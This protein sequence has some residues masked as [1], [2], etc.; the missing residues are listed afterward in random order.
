MNS[1]VLLG[2]WP[3]ATA[4]RETCR[5]GWNIH[6]CPPRRAAPPTSA[7]VFEHRLQIEGRAADDLEHVGGGGLLLQR[8]LPRSSLSSRVF[9]IAMTAWSAKFCDQ[10]D[11]L[12]GERADLL[13]ID[14]DDADQL[15]VLE[16][17]HATTPCEPGGDS[18]RRS[19]GHRHPWLRGA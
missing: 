10:L 11:L 12:V 19:C 14:D 17:R 7:S 13:A 6:A 1:A 15:V 2:E 8:V 3:F 4:Q 5:R 16:H 18:D 9:S